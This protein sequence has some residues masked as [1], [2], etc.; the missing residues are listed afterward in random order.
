MA[1]QTPKTALVTGASGGIGR[2]T[3]LLLAQKGYA[4]ALH[5]HQNRDAAETLC[6]SINEQGGRA[7]ALA[8]DLSDAE[9]ARTLVWEA[10]SYLGLLD[11]FVH[12]AGFADQRLFC[13]ISDE[14]WRKMMDVHVNAAFYLTKAALPAMIRRK[15]GS[16][17]FVSSMWG[18]VGASC[19]V[20]YS[21][22][23]AALIGLTKALAKEVGPSG[24]RVNCVAP[25]VIE[26]NMVSSF[27]PEDLAALAEETPLGRLGRP[28]E[29]ARAILF[30]V[31]DDASYITGQVIS[32]N[33]GLVV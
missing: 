24:V 5:Y 15:S 13:D 8:A 2:A 23:K 11:V 18:Q 28:E 31:S 33:G 32:P 27:S 1:T 25:G 17:V 29:V 30:L 21:T 9:Q 22:A 10:E 12:N 4:V 16:I 20:H 14:L 7:V 6:R 3:A 26:T 19:E